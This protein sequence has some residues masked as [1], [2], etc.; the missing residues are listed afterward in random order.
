MKNTLKCNITGAERVTNVPYLSK[1]ADR[2]GISVEDYKTF[3][4]SK[5]ALGTLKA[6]IAENGVEATATELDVPYGTLRKY[7]NYNGKNKFVA[8]VPVDVTTEEAEFVPVELAE[9]TTV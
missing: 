3:Y 6:D 4:V 5:A 9:L 8:P 7:I 1:K 2:L